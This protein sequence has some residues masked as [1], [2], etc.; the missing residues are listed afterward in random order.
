MC[1][2]YT[3]SIRVPLFCLQQYTTQRSGPRY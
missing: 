3:V 2:Q 1:R